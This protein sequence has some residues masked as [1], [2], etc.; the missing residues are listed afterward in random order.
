MEYT[1]S[2]ILKDTN[3]YTKRR[4]IVQVEFTNGTAPISKELEFRIGEEDSVVKK[5]F[6]Q[7]LQE[8]NTP[9]SAI[10]DITYV[11]PDPA[12][13]EPNEVAFQEWSSDLQRLVASGVA[14]SLGLEL[15]TTNQLNTLKTKVQNGMVK[16]DERYISALAS[17]GIRI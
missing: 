6:T 3:D 15:A 12:A 5:A 4:R 16:T 1:F 13:P 11:E 7:Y 14:S 10:Q 8:L 9:A 17:Y 2:R